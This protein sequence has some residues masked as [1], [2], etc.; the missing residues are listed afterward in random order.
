MSLWLVTEAIFQIKGGH[1]SFSWKG[2][3][4]TKTFP[5]KASAMRY[6][7]A[8]IFVFGSN[9]RGSHGR[10][11]AKFAFQYRNA[12]R[13]RGRGIQGQA[14]AI[15]TKD[16]KLRPLP[17]DVIQNHVRE[18]LVF[19]AESPAAQ[20]QVTRIGCGLAGYRDEQI[21]PMFEKAPSNCLLPGRW[22]AMRD[23]LLTRVIVAGTRSFE[24]YELMESKMD[25]L[26]ANLPKDLDIVSGGAP[27]AD[28]LGERYARKRGYHLKR[29]PADW[30]N[31]AEGKAAGHVR[32]SI[33]AWYA[34]HLVA[35]WNGKSPGTRDMIQLAEKEGL[36]TRTIIYEPF[37]KT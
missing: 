32:N 2:R 13:G 4:Q 25:R 34:T 22:L 6:L 37:P 15:P 11:A 10:G 35:F 19:A 30:D 29:F 12:V 27:G 20:F 36:A 31:K 14:Y 3:K 9:L 18:F 17:L 26:L 7:R 28:R 33:M 1:F 24:E 8:M 21:A 16:E 23:P 5:E